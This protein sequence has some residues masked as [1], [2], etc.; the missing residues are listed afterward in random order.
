QNCGA[1]V[2]RVMTALRAKQA[3]TDEAFGINGV[4]GKVTSSEELGVW[5]P[6]QVKTQSIKT[7]VEAACMLLRIDDIVSGLAKKKN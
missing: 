7:A 3:E 5:E 4:T 2:V 1:D 6:F